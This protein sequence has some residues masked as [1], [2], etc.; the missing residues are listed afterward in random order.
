MNKW[1]LGLE[2]CSLWSRMNEHL[3]F[4]KLGKAK[5]EKGKP[6]KRKKKKQGGKGG[7]A[8]ERNDDDNGQDY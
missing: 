2:V 4:R 3:I 5:E 8:G 7:G 6:E 1:N